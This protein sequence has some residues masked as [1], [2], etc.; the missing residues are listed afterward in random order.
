[1]TSW[2]SMSR[3]ELIVQLTAVCRQL[4]RCRS[5]NRQLKLK[6]ELLAKVQV[7]RPS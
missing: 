3:P 6:D 4:E 2:E 5:E 1:M 7:I